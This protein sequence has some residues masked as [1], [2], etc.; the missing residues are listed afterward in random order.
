MYKIAKERVVRHLAQKS[1]EFTFKANPGLV[2]APLAGAIAGLTAIIYPEDDPFWRVVRQGAL[3]TAIGSAAG[4]LFTVIATQF[5]KPTAPTEF[6]T[7]FGGLLTLLG[8]GI[9]ISNALAD[10]R[11]DRLV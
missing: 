1:S 10:N 2:V 6:D 7:L 3:G 4:V 5:N 11:L 8:A 9:G